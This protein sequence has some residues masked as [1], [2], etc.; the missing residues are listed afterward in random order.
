MPVEHFLGSLANLERGGDIKDVKALE[1][2]QDGTGK[3]PGHVGS[4]HLVGKAS[5]L[6]RVEKIA[7]CH[8]SI[9]SQSH[10]RQ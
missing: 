9:Q 1:R 2:L 7:K 5:A 6:F 3:G 10:H 8:R 4:G